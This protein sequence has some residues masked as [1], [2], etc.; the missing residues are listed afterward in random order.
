MED[1]KATCALLQKDREQLIDHN[2]ALTERVGG[3]WEAGEPQASSSGHATTRTAP[4][5]PPQVDSLT[6]SLERAKEAALQWQQDAAAA[7]EVTG[8]AGR[9]CWWPEGPGCKERPAQAVLP[10]LSRSPSLPVSLS[11]LWSPQRCE[12]AASSQR[13]AEEQARS[14]QRDGDRLAAELESTRQALAGEISHLQAVSPLPAHVGMRRL[15]LFGHWGRLGSRRAP[16]GGEGSKSVPAGLPALLPAAPCCL[17]RAS[18]SGGLAPPGWRRRWRR[19]SGP[20][21]RCGGRWS[22]WGRLCAAGMLGCSNLAMLPPGRAVCAPPTPPAAPPP[23]TAPQ[24]MSDLRRRQREVADTQE[25]AAAR[26]ERLRQEMAEIS[27]ASGGGWLGGGAPRAALPAGGVGLL[28]R[29]RLAGKLV[30]QWGGGA[31]MQSMHTRWLEQCMANPCPLVSP[32]AAGAVRPLAA[33]ARAGEQAGLRDRLHR[34][35]PTNGALVWA[36]AKDWGRIVAL[37]CGLRLVSWS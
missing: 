33:A 24:L 30:R 31:G 37:A 22:R 34:Q 13:A 26:E 3:G 1:I 4:P 10:P 19:A 21:R 28:P 16:H 25:L 14:L 7:A 20:R 11:S 27:E 9:V 32:A 15:D 29:G 2:A 17:T 36:R 6:G 5:P 23:S 18:P 35:V 8:W 12:A